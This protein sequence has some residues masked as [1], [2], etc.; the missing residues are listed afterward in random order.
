MSPSKKEDLTSAYYYGENAQEYANSN[1]MARNQ[2]KT[3]ERILQLLEDSNIGGNLELDPEYQLILDLGCGTGF[4]SVL[5]EDHNFNMVGIDLSF[6]MLLKNLEQQKTI[7]DN[8]QIIKI[9]RN[10][11]CAAIQR[12]PIRPNIFHH[13]ISISAFN[14]I[15]EN[16][17][18]KKAIQ[19]LLHHIVENLALIL[20]ENGRIIIEFYPKESEISYYLE[21][22]SKKFEGGLVIDNP[23]GRKEQKFLILRKKN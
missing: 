19:Q 21:S 14:F 8:E 11:I 16:I 3:S 18:D 15:L 22:F 6:D 17:S 10:I 13:I 12:L 1:W 23:K 9:P 20:K 2:I 7:E 4:S 5:F